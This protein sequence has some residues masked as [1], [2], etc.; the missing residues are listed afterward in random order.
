M[1]FMTSVMINTFLITFL[2][3]Q[4]T[5]P[6][7]IFFICDISFVAYVC[8]LYLHRVVTDECDVFLVFM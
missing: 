3:K 6:A 8:I 4:S 2:L 7:V 1:K 5:L